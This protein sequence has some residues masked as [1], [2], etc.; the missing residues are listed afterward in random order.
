MNILQ[1]LS[2]ILKGSR[3]PGEERPSDMTSKMEHGCCEGHEEKAAASTCCS[4]KKTEM[5]CCAEGECECK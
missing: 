4:M 2:F 3:L 1:K 5:S